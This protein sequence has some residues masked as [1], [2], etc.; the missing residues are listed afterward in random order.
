MKD[1]KTGRYLLRAAGLLCF[2]YLVGLILSGKTSGM[3]V[4]W[5][6]LIGFFIV[7]S[8]K[9]PF[10]YVF[11]RTW[12]KV[13]LVLGVA[14]I[15]L[16]EGLIIFGGSWSKPEQPADCIIVL[17]A[18][19]EGETPSPTLRY[20]LETAYQYLVAFPEVKAVVSGGQ[21]NREDISEAEA[22]KRYLVS[23]GIAPERLVLEDA[24]TDTY[25]N[26]R[27]SFALLGNDKK[28]KICVVTSDFHMFRAKLLAWK[29][30]RRV[31][32]WG[33][34]TPPLLVP[35]YHFREMIGIMKDYIIR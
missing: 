26:L 13:I 28:L 11:S 10:R 18:L 19:V 5:L 3:V 21:G 2:I 22:M 7:L 29:L 25:E 15:L 4:E 17:G 33:A 35:N 1:N 32:G 30:D 14:F 34:D 27:N 8:L 20:R 12:T 9:K 24:S 16:L 23:K 31:D 6:V